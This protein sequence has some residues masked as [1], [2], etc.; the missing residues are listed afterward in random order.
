VERIINGGGI[1]QRNRLLNRVYADILGKPVL[2]P[3]G[4]VTS[5]GSAIMAFL[6]ARTFKTIEEAQDALC[7]GYVTI[8]PRAEAAATYRELYPLFRKLYFS[9]GARQSGAVEVGD[10][11][12]ELRR[13]AAGARGGRNA[14]IAAE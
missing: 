11:L 5:L 7:P 10:I 6:A 1:P 8:D 2:V 3:N 9:F 4:D 14:G 13:I 12:P